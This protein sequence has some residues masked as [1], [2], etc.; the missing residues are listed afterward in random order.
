[1][2]TLS[3][4]LLVSPFRMMLM[5]LAR[6]P[7]R[8]FHI[9]MHSMFSCVRCE[10]NLELDSASETV[11]S[12]SQHNLKHLNANELESPSYALSVSNLP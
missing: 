1:M 9:C 3:I 8:L 7:R 12:T 6:L 10:L 4:T 2:L 11:T 5:V